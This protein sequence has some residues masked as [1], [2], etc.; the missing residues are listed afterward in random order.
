MNNKHALIIIK[1][2]D[3]GYAQYYDKEW[4]SYLFLNCKIEDE[5]DIEFIKNEIDNKFNITIEDIQLEKDIIHS[6]YSVKHKKVREYH[7]YFYVATIKKTNENIKYFSYD[8]LLNDKR[9]QEV[10]SDIVSMIKELNL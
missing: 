1:N 6:K 3:G 10:N 2:N 7:H 8:E 9:I 4:S 5:N